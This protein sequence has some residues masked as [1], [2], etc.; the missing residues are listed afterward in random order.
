MLVLPF[1]TDQFAGAAAVEKAGV[2]LAL[3][4]NA[5]TVADLEGAVRQL[6]DGDSAR[7]AADLGI[8]LRAVPGRETARAA[9]AGAR[10]A[11]A[12]QAPV[13]VSGGQQPLTR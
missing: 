12:E 2:G 9:F 6:L 10:P 8:T 11:S 4:P 7:A 3:D 1:S 13:P 5:A